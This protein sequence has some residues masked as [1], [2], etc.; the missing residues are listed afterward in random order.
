MRSSP[1]C[2]HDD[3]CGAKGSDHGAYDQQSYRTLHKVTPGELS[4]TLYKTSD[5][6][7]TRRV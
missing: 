4:F 6:I 5:R 1:K 3:G 7:S 2:V